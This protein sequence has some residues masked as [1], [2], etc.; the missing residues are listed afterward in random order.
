MLRTLI[1]LISLLL[2]GAISSVLAEDFQLPVDF[3]DS[4]SGYAWREDTGNIYKCKEGTVFHPGKDIN[5]VGTFNDGDKGETLRAISDGVVVFADDSKWA[6]LILQVFTE[7]GESYY[8]VYGHSEINPTSNQINDIQEARRKENPSFTIPDFAPPQVG[9]TVKKG[10]I[11]GLLWNN[12]TTYAHLHLEIRKD[13][14]PNPKNGSI[15]CSVYG[16]KS[17][18]RIGEITVDPI[19]F[20][21]S[22]HTV[23]LTHEGEQGFYHVGDYILQGSNRCDTANARFKI[24][25]GSKSDRWITDEVSQSEACSGIESAIEKTLQAAEEHGGVVKIEDVVETK[26]VPWWSSWS[27]SVSSFFHTLWLDISNIPSALAADPSV[28]QQLAVYRTGQVYGIQGT[29]RKVVI[30]TD[31]PGM[32]GDKAVDGSA[33]DEPDPAESFAPIIGDDASGKRPDLVVTDLWTERSSGNKWDTIAWGDTVCLVAVLKNSGN[34]DTPRD[35]KVTFYVSKGKKEDKHPDPVGS[36]T[37]KAKYLTKARTAK[38][39]VKHCVDVH[40]DNYPSAYPGTFNF[41]VQIDSDNKVV[42]SNEKNNWKGERIFTLM[43]NARLSVSQLWLSKANPQPGEAVTAYLKIKNTGTPFSSDKVNTE[44]RVQGPQYGPDPIILGFDQTRR[45]HLRTNDEAAEDIFFVV[46]TVPGAYAL[47]TEVDYDARVTQSNRSGNTAS[48][49]FVVPEVQKEGLD[50]EGEDVVD[51]NAITPC[52]SITVDNWS[53]WQGSGYAPPFDVLDGNALRVTPFCKK[54]DPH[55][56]RVELGKAGD[57]NVRTYQ[58][59]YV[60][61]SVTKLNEAVSL[62][63]EDGEANIIGYCQGKASFEMEAAWIDTGAVA[64][65]PTWILAYTAYVLEDGS[66]RFPNP[67]TYSI[68]GAREIT[69]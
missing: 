57:A 9:H 11:I 39:T 19:S 28:Q 17:R 10:D 27:S 54:N 66:Y 64:V 45:D 65:Y 44:W 68:Q 41:G 56:L 52:P 18:E 34:A 35:V 51:P 20:L 1:V 36:E 15:W 3:Q 13:G 43:E 40:G 2:Y 26:K 38:A 14:H 42:E 63:C 67:N 49:D 61:N 4:N 58:T 31:G 32:N 69:P 6:S 23:T 25:D 62:T 30:L 24:I 55:F 59:A 7:N 33:Y 37:V 5:K 8:V 60:Y 29:D 50:S 12:N 46:P 16:G 47:M 53:E 48:L 21:K 22:H